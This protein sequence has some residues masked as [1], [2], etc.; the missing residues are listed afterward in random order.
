[1]FT[2]AE[3]SLLYEEQKKKKVSHEMALRCS[4]DLLTT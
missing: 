2:E 3:T 4:Q 1:M